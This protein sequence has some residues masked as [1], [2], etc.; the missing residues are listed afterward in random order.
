M[1][2]DDKNF[3]CKGGQPSAVMD[4]VLK[5]NLSLEA[6]YPY[7]AKANSKCYRNIKYEEEKEEEKK[8]GRRLNDVTETKED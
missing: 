4:Y 6:D 8:E 3:A 5:H 7:S 1:D 2:C